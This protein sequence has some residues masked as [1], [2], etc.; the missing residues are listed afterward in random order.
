MDSSPIKITTISTSDK[1]GAGIA[2]FRLHKSLNKNKDV[3]SIF[4]NATTEDNPEHN[5]IQGEKVTPNKLVSLI[6]KFY[7]RGLRTEKNLIE[8]KQKIYQ[9]KLSQLSLDCEIATLPFTEFKIEKNTSLLNADIVHVHWIADFINYPSF[10]KSVKQPIV[11]TLH[12]MNPF[13]GLFHYKNDEIN[14]P[15]ARELDLSALNQKNNFINQH[16]NIHIVCLSEWMLQASKNSKLLGQYPHYLIPNGLDFSK[17]KSPLNNVELKQKLGIDNGNKTLLFVS[18]NLSNQRKGFDL[19][20]QALKLIT[21]HQFNIVTVGND[22]IEL[23]INYKHV[24]INHIDNVDELNEIYAAVDLLVLP[25]REDN[26]PNVMLEAFA[27]GTPVL[28]F[29]VGGMKDWIVEEKNGLL[30]KEMNP[31]FFAKELINFAEGKHVFDENFIK[32]YAIKHFNEIDQT[33]KYIDLYKTIID[34]N[35]K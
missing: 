27:N 26:L 14:N 12:D 23:P 18:Q 24:Q 3:S 1:G 35:L 22:K 17:I 9:K 5:L 15:S 8:S 20:S 11:W 31:E 21:A 28:G 33:Q 7:K 6:N 30:A 19:L 16:N 32:E 2:S 29:N 25:S 34:S 10:F 4:V 13:Q